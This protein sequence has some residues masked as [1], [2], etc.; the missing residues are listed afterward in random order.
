MLVNTGLQNKLLE[1]LALE[2]ACV[3][4][5]RALSAIDVDLNGAIQSAERR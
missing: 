3:T 2:R 5:P 1:A 4:T